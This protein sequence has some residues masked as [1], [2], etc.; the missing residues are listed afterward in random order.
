MK[1]IVAALAL[2]LACAL[3]AFAKPT[4]K[5]CQPARQRANAIVEGA[6]SRVPEAD[7]KA[8]SEGWYREL[9]EDIADAIVPGCRTPRQ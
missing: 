5:Q 1:K 2:V 4:E 7:R 3:P 6:K 9:K 8:F